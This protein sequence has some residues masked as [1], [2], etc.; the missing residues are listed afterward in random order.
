MSSDS[1][2]IVTDKNGIRT[3]KL[4]NPRKLNAF[5]PEM[6]AG[7]EENLKQ[8]TN[9]D[10]VTGVIITG[11][12]RYYS[13]G[14]DFS[15]T[16]QP[17]WPSDL[18]AHIRKS[19]Y[20]LFNNF[21]SFPKPLIMA[22]NGP[23]VGASAT[24]S[25]LSD[26]IVAVELASFNTP[27]AKLGL[28]PEGCSSYTFPKLLGEE[29]AS[30]VLKGKILSSEEA[31]ACGFIE[32]VVPDESLMERAQEVA[33]EYVASGK[34]KRWAEELDILKKT[35]EKESIAL[36]NAIMDVP[37]MSRQMKNAWK[38]G[39]YAPVAIFGLMRLTRPVW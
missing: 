25:R 13:A 33:E 6:M 31:H 9:D 17:M 34:P 24:S 10:K 23:A 21:L 4:N 36:A 5:T 22:L 27:F 30:K 26:V 14:V 2:L 20:D 18:K 15:G 3:I 37:F 11:T 16:I 8:A 32:Y 38:K 19:N 1:M 7:L 35:N 39:S 29:L 28:V 12:G